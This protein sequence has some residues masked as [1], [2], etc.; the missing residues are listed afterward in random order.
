MKVSCLLAPA[1]VSK[2]KETK[3]RKKEKKRK[4]D[5]LRASGSFWPFSLDQCMYLPTYLLG[6]K[7]VHTVIVGYLV[8]MESGRCLYGVV[9]S[10]S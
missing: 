7:L 3:K 1:R 8:R 5:T 10:E 4:K 9:C 6:S 2:K